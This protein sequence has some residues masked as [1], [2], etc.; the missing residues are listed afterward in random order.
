[1]G[2]KRGKSSKVVASGGKGQR[3]THKFERHFR[4]Y[5]QDVGKPTVGNSKN[6]PEI[7]LP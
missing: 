1:M 7:F 2:R 6:Q 4:D 3:H 5:Q